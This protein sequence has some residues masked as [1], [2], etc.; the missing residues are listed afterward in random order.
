MNYNY[1]Y[2]KQEYSTWHH[3]LTLPMPL[4]ERLMYLI[5]QHW[6]AEEMVTEGS[7]VR[8]ALTLLFI[9]AKNLLNAYCNAHNFIFLLSIII[10]FLIPS[11]SVL[12]V[13]CI[14]GMWLFMHFSS[15]GLKPTVRCTA[16][17]HSMYYN[18]HTRAKY[19]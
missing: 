3:W 13:G 7:M 16:Q 14:Q 10:Q 1:N 4:K 8:Y 11:F 9:T 18:T 12:M 2:N 6:E 17:P 5:G 19:C 15:D